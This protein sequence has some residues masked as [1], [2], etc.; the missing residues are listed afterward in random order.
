MT[1][2]VVARA[3]KPSPCGSIPLRNFVARPPWQGGQFRCFSGQ[4]RQSAPTA[5]DDTLRGNKVCQPLPLQYKTHIF[6]CTKVRNPSFL[7]VFVLAFCYLR[8][9]IAKHCN[10]EAGQYLDIEL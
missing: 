10:G 6:Y 2:Y 3:G 9:I 4:I 8:G 7:L 1:R 5:A